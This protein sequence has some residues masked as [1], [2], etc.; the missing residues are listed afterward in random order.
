[1]ILAMDPPTMTGDTD[2]ISNSGIDD[3]VEEGSSE[4]PS[5][6]PDE[7]NVQLEG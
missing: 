5:Q 2:S 6:N 1:M 4:D 7:Q 3:S